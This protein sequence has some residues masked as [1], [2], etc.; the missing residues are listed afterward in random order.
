MG[1]RP[2]FPAGI[3][4]AE[5]RVAAHNEVTGSDGGVAGGVSGSGAPTATRYEIT[6]NTKSIYFV[7]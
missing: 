2:D 1:S 5:A 7:H 3:Q 6:G 4:A